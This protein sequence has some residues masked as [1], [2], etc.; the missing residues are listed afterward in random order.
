MHNRL[1]GG[2]HPFGIG[3]TGRIGQIQN[4]VLLNLFRRFKTERRKIAD[5]QLDNSLTFFLHLLG[6]FH[7][8]TAYVVTDVSQLIGF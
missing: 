5:I 1:P 6:A 3:V 2:E 7:D 4:H 8:R